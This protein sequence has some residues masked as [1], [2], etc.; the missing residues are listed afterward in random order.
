MH[1]SS[2]H[3]PSL[4]LSPYLYNRES[5]TDYVCDVHGLLHV[6]RS[7]LL[8]YDLGKFIFHL[9]TTFG[10]YGIQDPWNNFYSF[11]EELARI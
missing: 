11:C 8:F 7:F 5:K 3:L 9:G 6:C 2:P 10:I 4:G 1:L